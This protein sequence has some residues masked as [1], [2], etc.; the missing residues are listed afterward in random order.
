MEEK[1][2]T[3]C[4]IVKPLDGFSKNMKAKDHRNTICKTCRCTEQRA[5]FLKNHEENKLNQRTMRRYKTYGLD[6]D[7]YLAML[8]SQNWCCKICGTKAKLNVDHCHETKTVRGLLCDLCN[9]GLGHFRDDK[10]LLLGAIL[11][12]EENK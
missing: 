6:Q 4:K 2:C 11:Y 12:L 7:T 10:N 8:E 5:R 1:A 3:R 9:W